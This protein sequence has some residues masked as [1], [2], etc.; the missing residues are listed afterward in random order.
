M[1]K[2]KRSILNGLG[3][4]SVCLIAQVDAGQW[5]VGLVGAGY[6]PPIQGVNE[7]AGLWPFVSYQ[8]ERLSID[9]QQITYQVVQTDGFEARLLGQLRMQG[10]EAGDSRALVGMR[11]RDLSF[12]LG[13]GATVDTQWGLF[14]VQLV[15][16][17]SGR[18][19]GQEISL[20]YAVPIVH[21]SW[22]FMPSIGLVCQSQNLVDYYYGVRQA[23]ARPNRPAYS[24]ATAINSFVELAVNYELDAS[25]SM[26]GGVNYTRLDQEIRSSPIVTRN[27]EMGAY[28][29]VQ[30]NF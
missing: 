21:Q 25:W 16:D 4:F 6:R 19:K 14:D 23:E 11:D 29:G 30:Y 22:L 20:T 17:V 8:S 24:G 3:L 7:E 2:H 1:I 9:F 12:D 10:Y 26:F 15:T 27:A 28:M 13:A 5:G 18:H